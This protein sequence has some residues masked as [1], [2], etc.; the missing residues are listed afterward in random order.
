MQYAIQTRKL[1]TKGRDM[2]ISVKL[3][4]DSGLNWTVIPDQT[5]QIGA[6]RRTRKLAY[7]ISIIGW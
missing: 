6:K 7:G 2:H 4:T 1:F 3:D 5:G